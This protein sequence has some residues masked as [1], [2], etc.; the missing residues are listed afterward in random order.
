MRPSD[1]LVPRPEGL[2]CPPG[3]FFIDPV[4]PV[5]RA[6]ITH[7]HADHARPGHG[8]VLATRETIDI[9][10][11]RMGEGLPA[12]RQSASIGEPI[13]LGGVTVRFHP[14]GHVLGLGADRG[15]AA[16]AADRR[17]R[18]LH[19]HAERDLRAVRAGAL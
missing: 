9:M 3:D 6:L 2:Y 7:A 18:G 1:L 8:A 11:I 10:A 15:R 16:R 17:G 13:E 14:A 5:P 4:R 19:P 12:D